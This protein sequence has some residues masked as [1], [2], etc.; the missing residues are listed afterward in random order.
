MKGKARR[1]LSILIALIMV[2]SSVGGPIGMAEGTSLASYVV[3]NQIYGAGGN[4]GALFTNDFIELYN[5]TDQAVNLAGWSVQYAS[6]SGTTYQVTSL[7]GTISA[8]GYYLIQQAA[9]SN[10]FTALPTPDDVG[11]IAMAGSNGKVA[12]VSNAEA[13]TGIADT[14]VVDY[15]GF[16]S[17]NLFEGTGATPAPS[18]ADAVVRKIDGV[19]SNDNS[20]D[21]EK[22]APN[23]RNSTYVDVPV[24]ETKCANVSSS[25]PGGAVQAGTQITLSSSTIGATIEYNLVSAESS[26]WTAGSTLTLT[27]DTTVYARAIKDGL[28]NSDVSVFAYTIDVSEPITVKQAKETALGTTGVKVQGIVSYVSGRNVY[29]QDAT[30]AIGLF[31]NANATKVKVGDMIIATG[32]RAEYYNLVQLSSVDETKI[33]VESSNNP[34]PDLGTAT[35][36]ELISTPEDPSRKAGYDHMCET[37]SVSGVTL[38]ALNKLTQSEASIAIYPVV[39]LAKFPGVSLSDTVN[40]TVR[41]TDYKGTLQVSVLE[42]AKAGAENNL[43]LTVTPGSTDMISGASVAIT[44]NDE[45]AS[46]Y[47]TL[48]GSTPTTDSTLYNGGIKIEGEIGVDIVLKAFAKAEGKNDSEIYVNTYKIKDPNAASTIKEVLAYGNQEK[49]DVTVK[50]TLVYFATTFGNPVIQS[51][52]DGEM[53]SLY[54][55]GAAPAGAKIGDEVQFTGKYL[56]Y[57]GLPEM[58]SI[59]ASAILSTGTP[60]AAQEVTV[61]DLKANGTKMIGRFIKVKNATLGTFNGSGNT[62]ITDETGSIN[63]YKPAPYPIQVVQGDI[64]DVYAMV[65]VYNS[66]VQLYT[67]TFEHNGFNIYDVTND[68]KPPVVTLKDGYLDAKPMQDYIIGATVADNKGVESVKITFSVGANTVSDLPMTYNAEN[69]E[70]QFTIP[71]EEILSSESQLKFTITATDVTGLTTTSQVKTIGIDNKPQILSVAPAR[72]GSTGE[73]KNPLITVTLQNA[74]V[75][76]EVNVTLEKDGVKLVDNATMTETASEGTF[77]YETAALVNGLYVV[78]V[79]VTRADAQT[80]MTTWSFVVGTPTFRP[81]FG[82]LHAHTAEYSDG[83][84]TLMDGLNY[85]K[86]I[87]AN[88]RVDFIALTDHSNYFDTTAAA[89]VADALNDKSL[90]TAT[91]LEKWNAY[92]SAMAN[93][94]TQNAGAKVALPGFEM[95]WSGGPG[96]INTFGSV[97]LVSRNNTSLNSKSADAG[98]KLYYETLIKNTDPLANLSQFNHPGST[99]GTFSEFAYW[100]AAYDN[101]MV[102]VEVGNGEGAIGSGGYFPSFTEYTKALDKGWHVAPTNNQDNHKGRW[103]NANTAR[104]VI[105]TDDLSETGLL[106]GLKNMSVYATEDKNLNIDFTVN[107][108]MMGSIISEVPTEALKFVVNVD[109]QDHGDV[110]AKV[111]IVTNSGRIAATKSFDSNAA[112]WSFELPAVQ[113]YYY[114]RVTQADKN[115]A[116]TAPIWVGQAPLVGISSFE[117]MTKLPVTGEAVSLTTKLFNNEAAPVTVKSITYKTGSEVLKSVTTETSVVSAGT[118]SDT[119]VYT[120]SEA[121]EMNVVVEAVI[122]VNGQEKM[123]EKSLALN[124]RDSEKLV[125]VGI[126]A[127]HF[128]EYVNGN[129]KDS[130]GNFANL[131][132]ESDVRVVELKTSEELISATQNS[133]F[134]MLILTPPTR[135]NGN[136]FLIGYKSYSESELAAIRTFAEAGNTIIVTG[137]GDYYE[138]YAK[139]SDGTAHVLPADQHMAYQQNLVLSAIGSTLRISDDEVKDD[140]SN[141]GQPMRLYLKNYNL[142]NPFLQFVKPEEQVYSNYG[143]ATVYAVSGEQTPAATLPTTVSP[144]V[145][146]FET[147]YSADD[148]KDGTTVSPGV[149]VPKYDNKYLVAASE[150][151]TFENGKTATIIAAGAVFM[152]NFEIQVTMDSYATPAYSNYTILENLIRYINPVVITD[153]AAVQA[154]EEGVSFTVTGIATSNASGYD[155]DT[156]F[157]DTIYIQDGTAGINVFPVSGD[158]RAGQTVEITG[159]TSSYNGERQISVEKLTVVDAA[160]KALPAPITVTTAQ[161]KDAMHL[162]SLVK[163]SGKITKLEYAN[164]VIESIY[165]KDGSDVEARVFIDGYITKDKSIANLA[166]GANVTAVGLSSIDTEGSRIRV[167]D[168]GDVVCTVATN[169]AETDN[170]ITPVVEQPKPVEIVQST[171]GSKTTTSTVTL[172][173]VKR[174]SG[175]TTANVSNQTI[176]SMVEKIVE[177]GTTGSKAI[178]EIKV[179]SDPVD[180]NIKVVIDRAAFSTVATLPDANV[181]VTTT[182]G[183]IQFDK[184]AVEMINGA[185]DSA[186]VSVN[187]VKMEAEALPAAI[188]EVVGER[189]VYD[190]TVMAGDQKVSSFGSG[191]ALVSVPYTLQQGENP[192]AIVIYYVDDSGKLQLVRGNYNSTTKTVDFQTTHFSKYLIGYNAVAFNDV[193]QNDWYHDAVSFVSSRNIANGTGTGTFDPN[194]SITRAQFLVMTMNAFGIKVEPNMADNFT[195]AGNAYFTAYL[196]TAKQLGITNGIGGGKFAPNASITRQDMIT[197]LYKTLEVIDEMPAVEGAPVHNM[198]D[199]ADFGSVASYAQAPMKMLLASGHI[200]GSANLLNPDG[201]ATRAQV[202]AIL[203]SLLGE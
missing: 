166:V 106:K 17:A 198:M 110:I 126:D 6:S 158:I 25:L 97:G 147:S 103:G 47:Y 68:T 78:T 18:A 120:P 175:Q 159:K 98:L 203:M 21:F 88:D 65:A 122:M 200:S 164:N 24:V 105:I 94:N 85:V 189:P 23:P 12:L 149:T 48:D 133:K 163:L 121:G 45:T 40:V 115:I 92:G 52:I 56:L 80:A 26:D 58:T 178:I 177:S 38:E 108:L 185:D 49:L 167:R 150:S 170:D 130:M 74:G 63:L 132:V 64:V 187:I 141:G 16:G 36:A 76:P 81:Y 182:A 101:K 3:I 86:N 111:D 112:Q 31:L 77:G 4:T 139:F 186:D 113:G 119:L 131:A 75:N 2:I 191:K 194:R 196:A 66:T 134:K 197:M 55:F 157:F 62:P 51:E 70:Y 202:A 102:A 107:D 32:T 14:D 193:T 22:K 39:D 152:S 199:F 15:V 135:R 53:Y 195:D 137:W 118:H 162:G 96:H 184:K 129:Y 180:S 145:Y 27:E 173:T 114:V 172:S 117:A 188:K 41:M 153:I 144:M 161:A 29:I 91:S 179:E 93:F 128:N 83:S 8:K 146:A 143:G 142:A 171:T 59:T 165:V 109:D 124:V 54:V 168:R 1:I 79:L 61:A 60:I 28:E 136:N 174:E 50:G 192:K 138:S 181:K 20:A 123:F 90:M 190:F 33:I 72:N 84:G 104:T 125:Y 30:A 176:T 19:D 82:Q 57:N 183:S 100:T 43:Y 201:L 95:T 46:I 160:I 7:T 140:V 116:V 127:S 99:F 37:I 9:G 44:S 67:G 155:K 69:S 13:I 73:V 87:E 5:P 71:S 156:A 169:V 35:I 151:V 154:A 34:I 42:M 11:N 89:N 10:T 148:D